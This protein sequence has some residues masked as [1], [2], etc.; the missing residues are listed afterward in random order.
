MAEGK[1]ILTKILSRFCDKEIEELANAFFCHTDYSEFSGKPVDAFL[2]E[3]IIGMG[4]TYGYMD[5][6]VE[7]LLSEIYNTFGISL[8]KDGNVE[9]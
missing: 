6:F 8:D 5:G 4:E 9:E 3:Y 1:E 7:N 2:N